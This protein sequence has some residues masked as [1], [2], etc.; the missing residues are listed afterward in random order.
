MV[1]NIM[2]KQTE[3]VFGAER[4][5]KADAISLF[6]NRAALARALDLSPGAITHWPD[7]EFI[8]YQHEQMLRWFIC[9]GNF[10]KKDRPSAEKL[11]L[12]MNR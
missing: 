5:T 8:P 4:L 2:D 3:K 6:K 1:K 11:V 7:G 10:R 9:P 12:F